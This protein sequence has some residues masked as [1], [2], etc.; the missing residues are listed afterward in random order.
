MRKPGKRII[1]PLPALRDVSGSAVAQAGCSRAQL[2]VHPPAKGEYTE[3]T[4]PGALAGRELRA[5][6]TA[7]AQEVQHGAGQIPN[8]GMAHGGGQEWEEACLAQ[9]SREATW[10]GNSQ[11]RR[12]LRAEP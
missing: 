5:G 4:V 1:R 12:W 9:D 10:E 2:C 7:Q 8:P 3:D 6:Q 11:S